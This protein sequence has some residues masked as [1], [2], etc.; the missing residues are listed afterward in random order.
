MLI[1]VEGCVTGVFTY[2]SLLIPVLILPGLSGL[3]EASK[4]LKERIGHENTL[5]KL[6]VCISFMQ[7]HTCFLVG[8]TSCCICQLNT[9]ELSS[10]EEQCIYRNLQVDIFS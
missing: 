2:L 4:V 10:R 8:H 9:F 6:Y 5:E 1:L 7:V 3:F